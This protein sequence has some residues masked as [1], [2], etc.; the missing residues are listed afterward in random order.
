MSAGPAL[1]E[2]SWDGGKARAASPP[3]ANRQS[4][5]VR[6]AADKRI[7]HGPGYH[8]PYS[9]IVIDDNSGEVLYDEHADEP[10]H[11]ASITKIMTL[12]LLFEQLGAGVLKLDTPLRVS[13]FRL[14]ATS[15]EARAQVR[16]DNHGRRPNQGA[17]DR[18]G[19]RCRGRRQ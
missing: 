8:P 7:V 15:G 16:S 2:P 12:Y 5:P 4:H 9:A 10:R 18:I 3:T 6:K 1:V 13:A 14:P 11:P 19:E 17:R